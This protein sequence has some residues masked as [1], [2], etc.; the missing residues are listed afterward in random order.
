M[1]AVE[2]EEGR[3]YATEIASHDTVA[4]LFG[5]YV[6]TS[7]VQKAMLSTWTPSL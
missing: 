3:K 7:A 5:R 4:S 2:Y 6:T 1:V